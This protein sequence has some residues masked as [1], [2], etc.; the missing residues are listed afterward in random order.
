METIVG[1]FIGLIVGA[2][3]IWFMTRSQIQSIKSQKQ[4][5]DEQISL[6]HSQ[7]KT[8]FKENDGRKLK[9]EELEEV[10]HSKEKE[11]HKSILKI[12]V[13]NTN[14]NKITE[15]LQ[16]QSEIMYGLRS[17]TV[18]LSKALGC[19]YKKIISEQ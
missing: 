1:L 19:I 11:N 16:S 7:N 12:D 5:N 17:E 18:N 8:L 2:G 4:A 10:I 3:S 6:L 9:I 14:L 15:T 13:L